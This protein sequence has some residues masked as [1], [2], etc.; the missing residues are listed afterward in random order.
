MAGAYMAHRISFKLELRDSTLT[1]ASGRI[2]SHSV[3]LVLLRHGCSGADIAITESKLH[4]V[5]AQRPCAFA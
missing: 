4:E 5:L 2:R 3:P 1:D